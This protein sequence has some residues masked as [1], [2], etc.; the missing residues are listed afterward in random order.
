LHGGAVKRGVQPGKNR[1]TPK[2][3]GQKVYADTAG[4][5]YDRIYLFNL[6]STQGGQYKFL[7]AL[8]LYGV[9]ENRPAPAVF[10]ESDS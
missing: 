7:V 4:K 1:N 10:A 2:P 8:T 5:R 6:H 3:V 9:L